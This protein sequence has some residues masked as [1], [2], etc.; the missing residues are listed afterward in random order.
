[1]EELTL[2][3]QEVA[4][5]VRALETARWESI[6][7]LFAILALPLIT[8]W[9]SYRTAWKQNEIA[10]FERRYG[11]YLEICRLLRLANRLETY[12]NITVEKAKELVHAVM[13]YEAGQP[14]N[15][16]Y[17]KSSDCVVRQTKFLFGSL[18]EAQM[19]AVRTMR[20]T[21]YDMMHVLCDKNAAGGVPFNSGQRAAKRQAFV[22]ACRCVGT[23]ADEIYALERTEAK[24]AVSAAG[25]KTALEEMERI[26]QLSRKEWLK[27]H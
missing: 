14:C 18:D 23:A 11:V 3:L 7:N 4:Q 17:L 20:E 9:F 16:E 27:K 15:T 8:F 22:D 26:L 2:Q 6:V 12:P 10:L 21:A 1:M 5:A 13:A 24:A 19:L 25:G